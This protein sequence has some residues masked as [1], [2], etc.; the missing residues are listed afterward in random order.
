VAIATRAATRNKSGGDRGARDKG[1]D[2]GGRDKGAATSA[3][4]ARRTVSGATTA[5]PRERD[6]PADPNSPL[7]NWRR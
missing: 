1:R 5:A 2:F 3:T 6:R 7:P 4:A